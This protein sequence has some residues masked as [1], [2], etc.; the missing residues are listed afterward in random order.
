MESLLVIGIIVIVSG[1][2]LSF[3]HPK[4]E[5]EDTLSEIVYFFDQAKLNSIVN[6][7]K[8]EILVYNNL[9][10]YKSNTGS[11][12]IILDDLVI[13]EKKTF[14]YNKM[15]NIHNAGTLVFYINGIRYDFVFQVGSGSYEIR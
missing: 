9:L 12:K 5:I 6:K 15:G 3:H 11:N 4:K 13:C 7:E 2:T 8:T 10:E 1:F 14:S